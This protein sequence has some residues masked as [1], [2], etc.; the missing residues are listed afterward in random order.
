[1]TLNV[2][3]AHRPLVGRFGAILFGAAA[4]A[5]LS[6]GPALAQD[7][8][9]E[10]RQTGSAEQPEDGQNLP[11]AKEILKKYVEATGG[12]ENYRNLKSQH[13]TGKFNLPAAGMEGQFE[14]FQ[15][16]PDKFLV[17][18]TLPGMGQVQNGVNGETGWS[19]DPM[20]GPRL[21]E[22][23]EL[24]S[25][26]REA[27]MGIYLEPDKFYQSMEVKGT[28]DVSGKKAYHLVMTP[29]DG[30]KPTHA[31][32]DMESG[33]MVRGMSTQ[34]SPM[35]EMN[36]E[37]LMEDYRKTSDGKF[38]QPHKITTRVGGQ[39]YTIVLDKI[40]TNAEIPADR[41]EP[42]A[43]VKQLVEQKKA[44][45]GNNAGGA[46]GAGGGSGNGGM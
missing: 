18:V 17:L 16:S 28:E 42:P 25:M 39:E 35:G 21:L 22:G 11:S 14:L 32:F 43:E 6:A 4:V 2:D 19:V 29:K 12:E 34:E 40:E 9:A 31:F 45:Q 5:A 20:S 37:T 30:G 44:Q 1:M 27:N 33:L 15:Q 24:K 23:Q 13:A 46:G 38:M 8:G 41:F 26:Q 36:A 10:R 7:R 3:T